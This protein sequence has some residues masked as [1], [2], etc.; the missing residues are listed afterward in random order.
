MGILQRKQID[1]SSGGFIP[2][3]PRARR[4]YVPSGA[5]S[6]KVRSQDQRFNFHY[7]ISWTI[8]TILLGRKYK[9]FSRQFTY[10]N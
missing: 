1:I 7:K 10:N 6:L 2:P 3:C 5:E 9:D 8:F 4:P